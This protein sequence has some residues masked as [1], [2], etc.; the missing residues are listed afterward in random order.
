MAG[1]ARTRATRP[2]YAPCGRQ[3]VAFLRGLPLRD[4]KPERIGPYDIVEEIEPIETARCFHARNAGKTVLLRC[5][6]MHGWGPDAAPQTVIDRERLALSRLEERDR[7]WQIHPELRRR[8]QAVDRRPGGPRAGQEPGH[9]ACGSAIPARDDGRLPRRVATDVVADAFHGL[10]EVHAAGLVHRG[11]SP[12]RIF[13]GR[14][15]RVKFSDFYLARVSG[16]QTIAHDVTARHDAGVPYRAPECRNGIAFATRASDVY[17]LAL[18]L[19]GWVLGD[20]PAE[21]DVTAVRTA[22]AA[23]AARSARCWRTAS[24]TTRANGRTRRRPPN[25]STT[26]SRRRRSGR[27]PRTGEREGGGAVHRRRGRR[28]QVGDPREPGGRRVR[29]HLAGVGPRDRHR[30]GHQAVP[31]RDV[32]RRQARVRHGGQHHITSSC[33]RVYDVHPG[34]PSYLVLEYVPGANLKKFAA[35]SPPDAARYR[36]IAL[37]VLAGLAYLHARGMIAPGPHAQQRHRHAGR[38]GEADRLRDHLAVRRRPP[39]VGTPAFMAPE[40]RAG[41]G[42]DARSDLYELGVTMIYA[43]LGRYPYAGD[44]ETGNDDRAR[45]NPPTPDE[46][47]AWGP[48]RRRDARRAVQAGGSRAR[49]SGPA[50]ADEVADALRLVDDIPVIAGQRLVNPVVDSLRGLYRASGIGNDDNRG[51]DSPFAR[52][53]YVPTRL[54]TELLPAIV[55]GEKRLVAADRQP[56]GRQDVV[57]HEGR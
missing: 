23:V 51:L 7:T 17:S 34:D 29:A 46:R 52:Q 57:S 26:R 15:L 31:R 5:Y 16:E 19:S 55:A 11:L 2:G 39:S 28:R 50:S 27:L 12:R 54:D 47:E 56:G 42:A 10:A 20:L 48:A 13:L 1:S 6:P 43:M 24:P 9:L 4:A 22:I 36:V 30:P 44:P 18:A 21:P 14:G 49:A 3:L 41:K 53:T 32:R 25:G 33:A 35:E 40:Q 38:P 37:D 8:G 45:L